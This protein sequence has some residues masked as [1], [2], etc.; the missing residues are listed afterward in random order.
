MLALLA[1]AAALADEPVKNVPKPG[2]V[3]PV[4]KGVQGE[5]QARRPQGPIPFP[6][7]DQTWQRITSKHFVFVSAAGETRTREMAEQLET[8]A[9]ALGRL[10]PRFDPTRAGRTQVYVFAR[11]REVQPYFDFLI[12]R[13]GAHVTG[14]FV[15]QKNNGSAIV[16]LAGSGREDRTPFHELVHWLIQNGSEPPLWL[17][18][19]LAEVFG[20]SDLRSGSLSIGAGVQEHLD[21]LKRRDMPLENVFRVVRESDTYNLAEGQALFYAK[22]WAVV[23]W[24]LRRDNAAFYDFFHDVESGTA[25]DVALQ[26]RYAMSVKDLERAVVSYGGPLAKAEFGVKMPIPETDKSVT[27]ETIDRAELLYELGHF[28]ARFDELSAE[29]ERHF[30]AAIDANPRHAR[31]LAGIA[32]LRATNKLYDDATHYFEKAIAADPKDAQ[33]HIEYA[34]ALMQNEIGPLAQ[35]EDVEPDDAPRFRKARALAQKALDLGAE[36]A[37]AAGDIGTSYIVEKPED[38]GPG[39]A[40]LEKAHALLP[41]RTDFALHL[42]SMYRRSGKPADDLFKQLVNA[43]SPQVR[44]AA[45]AILVRIDL[46]RTN[47]L[48]KNGKYDDAAAILRGLAANSPDADARAD[49]EK[50]AAEVARAGESNRQISVYNDAVSLVNKGKYAAARKALTDLLTTATDPSVIRDARKLQATLKGR[51]DLN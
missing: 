9:A 8:L 32:V 4:L 39:I 31:G 25:V 43:R 44:F 7:P 17:E 12:N 27:V 50:Q 16:M 51:K 11:K 36:P 14:L 41:N 5:G 48:L 2:Y 42:F 33:I 35:A 15:S 28:F 10:N 18:E 30:R 29:A 1:I 34:E 21:V 22:S 47:E 3:P 24:L 13:S 6:A 19:G 26:K 49:F 40:A 37:R 45:R 46:A 38:L 20:H 23:D